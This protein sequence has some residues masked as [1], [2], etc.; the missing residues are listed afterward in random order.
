MPLLIRNADIVTADSRQRG[1]IY[2]G[3]ETITRI[4]D[5]V[6]LPMIRPCPP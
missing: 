2:I 4:V 6:L 3:D 1:D 5:N